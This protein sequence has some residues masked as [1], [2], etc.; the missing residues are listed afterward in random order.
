MNIFKKLWENIID[1]L[2][3]GTSVFSFIMWILM[4]LFLTAVSMIGIKLQEKSDEYAKNEHIIYTKSETENIKNQINNN[5]SIIILKLE[6]K[7]LFGDLYTLLINNNYK[8]QGDV[9]FNNNGYLQVMIK[10]NINESE[11][12]EL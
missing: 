3:Y 5:N 7:E 9:I 1:S 2:L 12:N 6:D 4:L 8:P 11:K 10:N